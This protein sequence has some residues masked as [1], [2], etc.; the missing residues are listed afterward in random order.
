MSFKDALHY[1]KHNDAIL[2][3]GNRRIV[4]RYAKIGSILAL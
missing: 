4:H 3:S 2:K 1:L